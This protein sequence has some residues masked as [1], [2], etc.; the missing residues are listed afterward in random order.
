MTSYLLLQ[1]TRILF[2]VLLDLL[3]QANSRDVELLEKIIKNTIA[4]IFIKFLLNLVE[5]GGI[6]PPSA[7]PPQIVLHT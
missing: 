4:N 7:N 1:S 3:L 6:E 5:L 2:G